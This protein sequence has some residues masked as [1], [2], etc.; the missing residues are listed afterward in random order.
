MAINLLD[1]DANKDLEKKLARIR[2]NDA[3]RVVDLFSGC[4]GMSLGLKRAHYDILGG[5]EFNPNAVATY[6]KNI[7]KGLD[8]KS[9]EIHSTA[10]D[11]TKLTPE[12]FLQEIL[13]KEQPE[14]LVDIIV[15][16]P[17]CQAFSRIGRAKLRSVKQNPQAFLD[18]ER[19]NL[20]LHYLAYVE[21]FRPLAVLMENVTDI[22]NYGGTNVA[23]EIAASLEALGYR[24]HYTI[25][26]TAHYGIPQL[27][28]R[29]YLIAILEALD[30]SPTFPRPTHFIR[31]PPG[32]ESAHFVALST[33]DLFN[34]HT[35]RYV[36]P[37]QLDEALPAAITVRDA[38]EDL[39][40]ITAHLEGFVQR[41][42]RKFDTLARYV[43]NTSL[44]TYA[45]SMRT[46]PGFESDKGVLDHV[47]RSL[48]RD[49]PIF[50]RMQYDD[51]YPEA[52]KLAY[53]LFYERLRIDEDQQNT[54]IEENSNAYKDL[55]KKT[56][57]PYSSE[58]FPNKWWKLHP[59][60]PS[61]TLTAHMGKDTYSHIHYDSAQARV[62]SVREAARLQSF[63]DGFQFSGA[64]N[65]AFTQIG[66]AVA[67]LQSYVLGK[68]ISEILHIAARQ[69]YEIVSL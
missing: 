9:L 47:I 36:H 7:F 14:N 67:P 34:H 53:E 62:I 4:G 2:A 19:S 25:L 39:P 49:Y 64:M 52:Y 56:V 43:Q 38:I 40:P 5:I 42:T 69:R 33:L 63:P 11:I 54:R 26:N 22:M 35:T 1:H 21:F 55:F 15:G 57:P 65:S 3:L 46:W 31:L 12:R 58:K 20:Y 28:Q 66:N 17:P 8:E 24:C 45:D 18:D 50:Q 23:E 27:R 37:P 32:Y 13:R 51:Q 41:G 6:S 68:H 48:P 16:G 60:Q 59:E 44:S 30:L 29:F 61:R 10:H